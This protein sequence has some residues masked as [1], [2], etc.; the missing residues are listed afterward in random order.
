[1]TRSIDFS[2]VLQN[3]L[4]DEQER[5]KRWIDKVGWFFFQLLVTGYVED[6][7]SG[8]CFQL[9]VGLKWKIYVEVSM[10]LFQP[11][12]LFQCT[13]TCFSGPIK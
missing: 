3:L 10:R 4:K 6:I 8:E 2:Y 12:H 1:M 5:Y 11:F 9:P 7:E 13:L